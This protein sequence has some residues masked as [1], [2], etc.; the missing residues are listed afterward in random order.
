LECL[1][2][3]EGTAELSYALA[4][5]QIKVQEMVVA[6]SM[7]SVANANMTP[8]NTCEAKKVTVLEMTTGKGVTKRV[9]DQ[10]EGTKQNKRVARIGSRQQLLA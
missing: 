6:D 10:L 8:H 2:I 5:T 9:A 1:P 7:L 3:A 4:S